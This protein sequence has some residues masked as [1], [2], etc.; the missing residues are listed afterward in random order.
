MADKTSDT[1]TRKAYAFRRP[2]HMK[3]NIIEEQHLR[4]ECSDGVSKGA[5]SAER[6]AQRALGILVKFLKQRITRPG[7]LARCSE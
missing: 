2:W 6:A 5:I 1:N 4:K 3:T 7:S